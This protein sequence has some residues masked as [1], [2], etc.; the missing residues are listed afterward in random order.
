MNRKMIKQAQKLQAQLQRAQQELETTTVVGT[1]GGGVVKVVMTGKADRGI[2]RNR[3]RSRRRRRTAPGSRDRR[4]QR[5]RH[6]S[7]GNGRPKA[8][9]PHRRTKNPRPHVTPPSIP[10]SSRMRGPKSF[11]LHVTPNIAPCPHVS[12][13]GSARNLAA[14]H[15]PLL[16]PVFPAHAGTHPPSTTPPVMPFP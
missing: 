1:A 11:R 4:R 16:P 9:K 12:F 7:S 2:R 6:E 15:G 5:R 8:W 3:P 14:H 13:R 10:L